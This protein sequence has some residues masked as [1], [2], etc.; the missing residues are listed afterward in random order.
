MPAERLN[1]LLA[2]GPLYITSGACLGLNIVF[3]PE[4]Q[5]LSPSL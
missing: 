4:Y 5:I 3:G 2:R 1:S